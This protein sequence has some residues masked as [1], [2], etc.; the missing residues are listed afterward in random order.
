MEAIRKFNQ[1]QFS[2]IKVDTGNRDEV[3]L[4]KDKYHITEEMLAYAM[5][6]NENARVEYDADEKT[7]LLIYNVPQRK[8]IENHYET[9]PITFIIKDHYFISFASQETA[10]V[11]PLMET[12]LRKAPEQSLYSFLFNTLFIISKSFFPLIDSVDR[13]RVA[14]NNKLRNKTTNRNLLALSDIEVGLVYLVSGTKQNTVLLEQIKA[15]AVYRQ[16]DDVEREQ[17]DDVV[18]EAKQAV[19]MTQ[20]SSQI[21]MQLSGTYNNLLNNN[22]NDTMK[23]LTV[24][25]LLLTV[26][27][28][29]TG[30]FGMNVP[31]PLS[32]SIFSW[33]IV[34]L[35][36]LALSFW[37]LIMMWR[38]IK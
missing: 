11:L 32:N 27:T 1:G 3:Q 28:I 8:K 16:L 10:Y 7:F 15:L 14:L 34:I 5:D 30:F 17:L 36:S 6:E 13:D 33:G 29:V 22:L 20:L 4:L 19:E 25:S 12:I 24:W 18:I 31:L 9:R 35:I 26:P 37:L 38:I 21:L 2:W 23:V